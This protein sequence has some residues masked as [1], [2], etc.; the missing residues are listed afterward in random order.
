MLIKG[1]PSLSNVV[2][3]GLVPGIH[4]L[5]VM[6]EKAWVGRDKPGQDDEGECRSFTRYTVGLMFWLSRK[7][8]V[9]SY[10]FFRATSRS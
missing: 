8:F 7:R 10:L 9:G 3:P 2:V 1:T 5:R 4:V 6:Q